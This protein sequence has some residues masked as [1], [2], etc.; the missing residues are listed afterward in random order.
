[1]SGA[2]TL[3]F[4]FYGTLLD[5]DVRAAVLGRDLPAEAPVAATLAGFRRVPVAGHGFPV[6]IVDPRGR[7]EG[8]LLG[9]LGA[10]AAAR[11]SYFEGPEYHPRLC[12][13]GDSGGTAHAAWV[14]VPAPRQPFTPGLRPRPG[15]W[16]LAGWQ[17]RHKARYMRGLRPTM[18]AA[19]AQLL[20][21]LRREWE[22]RARQGGKSDAPRPGGAGRAARR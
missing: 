9:G 10:G 7:V 12:P 11:L 22:E 8:A 6:V 15:A 5:D 18:A 2:A 21:E 3:D 19:P 16:D 4:F 14:F 13:I 17:R 20:A 1:M